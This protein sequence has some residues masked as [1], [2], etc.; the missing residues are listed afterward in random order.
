M[1]STLE[2][3]NKVCKF[4]FIG[5][6]YYYTVE[7]CIANRGLYIPKKKVIFT[8]HRFIL[9]SIYFSKKIV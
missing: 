8:I 1:P 9:F 4:W 5:I 7:F 6:F 2:I 3:K